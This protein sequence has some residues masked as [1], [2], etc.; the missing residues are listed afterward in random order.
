MWIIIGNKHFTH[1]RGRTRDE[2]TC[3]HCG[4][5]FR[6]IL[7]TVSSWFTFTFVP[8]FPYRFKRNVECPYCRTLLRVDGPTYDSLLST[9]TKEKIRKL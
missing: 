7:N 4:R 8:I 1:Y 3:P 9:R 5:N 2:I 6:F